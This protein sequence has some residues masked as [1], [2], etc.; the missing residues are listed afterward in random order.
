MRW[1]FMVGLVACSYEPRLAEVAPDA[2]TDALAVTDAIA[3]QDAPLDAPV[4]TVTCPGSMC[5]AICCE[6][7]CAAGVCAGTVFQCDGPEDCGAN[8]RCCN[9]QSGSTCQSGTCGS[10]LEVC[11]L[12]SDCSGSCGE[13]SFESEFGQSVCCE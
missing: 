7:T 2:A 4:N 11:H 13:C 3:S 1:A 10:G 5:G 12:A 6:G 9:D 8:E